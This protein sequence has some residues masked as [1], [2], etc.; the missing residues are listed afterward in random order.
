MTNPHITAKALRILASQIQAPDDIPAICLRDAADLIER[1]ADQ[2]KR[3][4]SSKTAP[5]PPREIVK[6]NIPDSV[7]MRCPM[8]VKPMKLES[9]G[10]N[11]TGTHHRL[12][13]CCDDCKAT[14]VMDVFRGLSAPVPQNP[15]DHPVVGQVKP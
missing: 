2:I 10:F 1:Q 12:C 9:T 11:S 15:Q 6:V 14:V 13:L 4:E 3:L 7:A 5:N 8:C